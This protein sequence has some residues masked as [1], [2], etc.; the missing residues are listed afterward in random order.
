MVTD[1]RRCRL[2][3][4]RRR[5]LQRRAA[6]AKLSSKEEEQLLRNLEKKETEYMR[7][8]RHKIGIDD[9]ELLTLIGKGAFGENVLVKL[10]Y[11]EFDL[12]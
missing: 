9:F 2:S 5:A 6:E 7:L 10:N 3:E 8:Q 4:L 12:F 1:L 11:D